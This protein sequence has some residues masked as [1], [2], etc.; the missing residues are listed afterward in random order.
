MPDRFHGPSPCVLLWAVAPL[1]LVGGTAAG[2]VPT[3][4]NERAGIVAGVETVSVQPAAVSLSRTRAGQQLVVTGRG[5]DKTL[6]DLTPFCE[7]LAEDPAVVAVA[8]GG[9]V[10]P[11]AA[12]TTCLRVRAGG[13][14]V[15]VPVAVRGA[16]RPCPISFRHDVVPALSVG[17]CNSGACHGT[18]SGKN[19]FRLS[20]RG[21]DPAADYLQLTRDVQGRRT[22]RLGAHESLIYQKALGRVPHEGGPRFSPESVPAQVMLAWLGEGLRD[23]PADLPALQGV[24][25]LPGPRVLNSPAR[26]QQLAVVAHFADGT[27]RDVTR[28]TVFSSSDP[29]VAGVTSGGL[30][31]FQQAGE[32]AILCRYLDRLVSVR[33]TY[34][35]AK[36]GFRWPGPAENNY[37][38]RYAFEK[39]RTLGIQPSELCTD[40]EFIRRAYLD[41]C[42]V[43]PTADEARAFLADSRPDKRARL[44]DTLLDRPEYADFWTL[45]W[46]DVL[47]SHRKA[48]Q[49]K[50][51]HVFQQWLRRHVARNT[52]LDVV[53][54]ELLTAS[55][56]AFANPAAN[57]YRIAR[58]PQ[59]LAETTAQLFFGVRMQCCKC[60]NHP[61]ERWTQ[62]DYYGLAAFFARVRQKSDPTEP[63]SN[64]QTPGGEIVYADRSG[65]VVQ[66]RTG[67]TMP[68]KFL[69]GAV[70]D[71]PVGRDRREVFAEWLTG[72]G[73]PFFAR[74]VA[75]RIWF[76]LNRRGIVEPVDDFRDS[77]PSANDALLDAL[78]RDLVSHQFDSK[79]LIRVIVNSR[80]YQL[81]A[82]TNRFNENDTKYFSHCETR[83][84]TAEQ[85]LDGVC[86]VT[87]VPE[88]YPGVPPGTRAAQLPDGAAEHPFLKAFGQPGR[89]LACECERESDSNL[90]QAL[91]LI[92]GQT[93]NEKL[94]RPDNRIGRL[95]ARGVPEEEMLG[96]LYLAALS[97]PPTVE[98]ARV[99]RR[100]LVRA[101][102]RRKAWEDVLWVLLNTKEFLFRH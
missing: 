53:V 96:E 51:V 80:T 83:L 87:E 94:R 79:H 92:N 86:A 38:D 31:E 65:E 77:N 5:A 62:D 98:E 90:G 15:R 23:D 36:E 85:L 1:V 102:D 49:V 14:T 26:W 33:L 45:K 88:K 24:D 61:F 11:K 34:L 39:M 75:N 42:G 74:A 91:Q 66:P 3:D 64:P 54:R 27:A 60:H 97:R 13:Q 99:A 52:P 48:I 6:R 2:A 32:V 41:V 82:L 59:N 37:V 70:A 71:E 89:E 47:R 67:R 21:Y 8:A 69:G 78:A 16:D 20:L 81:S 55:G 9:L 76:H 29:A 4:A 58:D 63:G 84:Y 72:A 7:I 101:G 93:V 28:L 56:N 100:H 44:V 50:G 10:F 43:L 57:Y 12:G 17:G 25:I 46:S 95:L 19:G 40:P 35:E 22:D 30:V 68:P 18:P 73:N